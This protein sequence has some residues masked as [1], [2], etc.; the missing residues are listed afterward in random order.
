MMLF[1]MIKVICLVI[2][3]I[4]LNWMIYIFYKI[5]L[6]FKFS[7]KWRSLLSHTWTSPNNIFKQAPSIG[8]QRECETP[9]DV[10]RRKDG[11]RVENAHQRSYIFGKSW[12]APLS[13]RT[14]F[15]NPISHPVSWFLT[16]SMIVHHVCVITW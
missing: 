2:Y 12:R 3:C 4:I 13:M 9:C 11:L 7:Y 5:I 15:S 8:V 6:F 1:C 14:V 10:P 16:Y